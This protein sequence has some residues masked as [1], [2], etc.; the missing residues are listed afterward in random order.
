MVIGNPAKHVSWVSKSGY[1]LNT[2]LFC[3]VE[4]KSYKKIICNN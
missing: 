3:K 4:K 2:D 1:K